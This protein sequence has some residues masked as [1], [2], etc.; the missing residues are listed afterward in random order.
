MEVIVTS[1][2]F[3]G[4]T[5]A[6]IPTCKTH[7]IASPLLHTDSCQSSKVYEISPPGIRSIYYSSV[8]GPT[9]HTVIKAHLPMIISHEEKSAEETV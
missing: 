5:S 3:K 9:H 8:L 7:Q 4:L 2:T 6:Q 1:G